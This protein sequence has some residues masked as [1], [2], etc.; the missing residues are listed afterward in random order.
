MNEDLEYEY[1]AQF[2]YQHELWAAERESMANEGLMAEQEMAED[3][4]AFQDLDLLPGATSDE[5]EFGMIP[6]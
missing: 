6:F 1:N 2:D 5:D 3:A 4:L